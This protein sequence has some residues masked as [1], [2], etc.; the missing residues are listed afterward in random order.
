MSLKH[1][2]QTLI[3]K[4]IKYI[5]QLNDD[6]GDGHIYVFFIF[7]TFACMMEYL[8]LYNHGIAKLNFSSNQLNGISWLER[9]QFLSFVLLMFRTI[10]YLILKYNTK[11]NLFCIRINNIT[12]NV[13]CSVS[14]K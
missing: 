13:D 5:S 10:L 14:H 7:I 9:T 1:L 12:V 8:P 3:M 11:K 4:Y 6:H 2:Q